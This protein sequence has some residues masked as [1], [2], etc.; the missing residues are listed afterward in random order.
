[1]RSIASPH[2]SISPSQTLI[3]CNAVN[4]AGEEE[5]AEEVHDNEA[6]AIMLRCFN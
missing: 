2:A 1:M 5:V 6:Q 4:N 3:L